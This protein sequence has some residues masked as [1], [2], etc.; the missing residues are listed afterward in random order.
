MVILLLSL[1][2]FLIIILTSLF[3][4]YLLSLKRISDQFKMFIT[5]PREGEASPLGKFVDASAIMIGR[6][7]TAQ[8]KATF[9]SGEASA[10]RQGKAIAGDIAED[11]ASQNPILGTIMSMFPRVSKSIRRN[12]K[13]VDLALSQL[14]GGGAHAESNTQGGNGAYQIK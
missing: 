8:L 7:I 6:A 1:I 5:P 14:G 13:L 12:P 3:T 11:L 9:M 10:A 4:I 2:T